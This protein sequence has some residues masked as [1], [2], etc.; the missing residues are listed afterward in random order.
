M[1]CHL[2][3][4]ILCLIN[5]ALL[6]C[7][8]GKAIQESLQS[9]EL[10]K[11]Q[12]KGY[13]WVSLKSGDILPEN[14]VL[15]QHSGNRYVGRARHFDEI[16]PA[17]ITA[18]GSAFISSCHKEIQKD[19][20]EILTTSDGCEWKSYNSYG[21]LE[22]TILRVGNA[23]NGEPIYIA[24]AIKGKL[25]KIQKENMSLVEANASEGR[26]K[27]KLDV[28]NAILFLIKK[29]EKTFSGYTG[30]EENNKEQPDT[31]S[32]EESNDA[33]KA[34]LL[35]ILPDFK[36]LD[37]DEK[38]EFRLHTLQF[39][40]N[41]RNGNKQ[42]LVEPHPQ[43]YFGMQS[44]N[45]PMLSQYFLNYHSQQSMFPSGNIP[46]YAGNQHPLFTPTAQDQSYLFGR[47]E[48]IFCDSLSKPKHLDDYLLDLK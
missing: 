38:L 34:F 23:W 13:K 19:Q 25:L 26:R 21:D 42:Q 30:K 31:E 46:S 1:N 18:D 3:S 22:E 7:V 14:I 20:F 4:A 47:Q 27:K 2:I 29:F 44:P 12:S 35:S 45:H 37:D 11:T 43:P 6:S 17:E 5:I 24:K 10:N 32:L 39:F 28:V 40:K 8:C 16:L 36:N 48:P 9:E 41:I 15:I 33:D